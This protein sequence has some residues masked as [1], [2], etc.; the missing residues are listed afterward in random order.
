MFRRSLAA[1]LALVALSAPLSSSF[2]A[3]AD[4]AAAGPVEYEL[5]RQYGSVLFRVFQQEYLNLVGRFDTYSGTLMLDPANLANSQLTATVNMGSLNM[6]DKDVTETLVN[7]SV[8]FNAATFPDATFKSTSATVTGPN[9]V[10]FQ[11]DLSFIG[12]T[13]PWTLHVKFNPGSSG[14]IGSTVGILG[15]GTINRLDFGMKEYLNMAAENV[16]IEVN[17]KFNRK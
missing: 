9:E 7:S 16:E 4:A 17:V 1:V 15:T 3:D 8:W 12:M 14:E 13:K 5:T 6:A 2:A 10:D 11:G